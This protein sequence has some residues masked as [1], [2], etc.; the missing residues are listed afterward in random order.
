MYFAVKAVR[1]KHREYLSFYDALRT[2]FTVYVIADI[3]FYVFYYLLFNFIDPELE[4]VMKDIALE[5]L[6]QA[7][8]NGIT[9]LGN[10]S[11]D[12]LLRKAE[13]ADYGVSIGMLITQLAYGL[14]G[15]F[16][17]ALV[18]ALVMK[19]DNPLSNP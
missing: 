15:G 17:I 4:M 2:G 11:V 5:S 18:I 10:E 7:K 13:T 19:K 1:N 6:Q 16:L 9:N 12:Q 3:I 14:I 8:E